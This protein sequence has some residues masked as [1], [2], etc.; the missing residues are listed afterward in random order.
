MTNKYGQWAEADGRGVSGLT[1]DQ[2]T[3]VR[4]LHQRAE[5]IAAEAAAVA[6][7]LAALLTG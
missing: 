1:P 4:G 7:L 5:V 2:V 3:T 6:A